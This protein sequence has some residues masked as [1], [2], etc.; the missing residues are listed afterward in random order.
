MH[1]MSLDL[2][3]VI[4]YMHLLLNYIFLYRSK[5]IGLDPGDGLCGMGGR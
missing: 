4:R 1:N 2:P 3:I 5:D